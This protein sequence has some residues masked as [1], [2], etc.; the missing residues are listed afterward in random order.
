ML[1]NEGKEEPEKTTEE[2]EKIEK[3]ERKGRKKRDSELDEEDSEYFEL[4]MK[5]DEKLFDGDISEISV[6][7]FVA[8]RYLGE[9]TGGVGP[10]LYPRVSFS[11]FSFFCW[12][13][14][15]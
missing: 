14:S 5:V 4:E 1:H 11:L 6:G 9:Y 8:F 15:H 2:G 12:D 13:V 3:T 10:P 7:T